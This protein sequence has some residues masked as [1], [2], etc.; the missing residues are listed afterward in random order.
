MAGNEERNGVAV[1]PFQAKTLHALLR[2]LKAGDY[3]ILARESFANVVE[4]KS[5]IKQLWTFQLLQQAAI[6]LV[7][8]GTGLLRSMQAFN[9]E[10]GMF[11]DCEAMIKIAH[12]KRVDQLKLGQK[13]CQQTERMH[14]TQGVGCVRLH[15]H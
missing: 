7:P 15:Q 12:D 2:D 14:R 9:G 10:E 3:V 4:Q 6:A 13:N 1:S 8:L 5:E 11:V